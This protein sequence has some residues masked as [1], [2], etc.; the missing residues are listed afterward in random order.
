MTPQD[1]MNSTIKGLAELDNSDFITVTHYNLPKKAKVEYG[2]F[3]KI[4][5]EE[6]KRV[7]EDEI[8]FINMITSFVKRGD[9]ITY[10]NKDYFVEHWTKVGD[11][12]FNVF[13]KIKKRVK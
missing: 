11:G 1:L 2:D 6:T 10:E 8:S 13:C 7:L 9:N 4:S 12:I 3:Q 5:K